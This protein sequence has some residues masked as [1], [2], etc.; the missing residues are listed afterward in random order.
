MAEYPKLSWDWGT[1]YDL[2]ISLEVLHHPSEFGVRGSWASSVR[3]RLRAPERDV[4]EQSLYLIHLP[5]HWV[6]A[7]PDPKDAS[8]V[9][10]SLG[11]IPAAERLSH[12]IFHDDDCTIENL[13][14][15]VAARRDWTDEDLRAFQDAVLRED[16]K[17]PSSLEELAKTLDGWANAEEFGE[18]YLEALQTYQEVFFSEEE[19]RIKPALEKALAKA[20]ALAEELELPDLLEELSQG[21]RFTE[22]PNLVEL[23]LAPSYWV[24]PLMYFG[25]VSHDRGV[26][27]FGA[28]PANESLVPGE[29]V[30]D[31][32][33]R[34]LKA[35]SDPTRLKILHYLS[36]EALS[37]VELS[38]RLR[39][40]PP[41]V[42]HHLQALRLAGLVKVNLGS[43]YGKEKKTFETRTETVKATY[44]ALETYISQGMTE[45]LLDDE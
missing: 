38:R 20:Q 27:M 42:T 44:A 15:D 18:R 19:K 34:V 11:Q 40:R 32:L 6:H 35:V 4:L 16:E 17:K 29:T 33:L 12:L 25:K 5:L 37:P 8:A 3:K 41:T 22:I 30:P 45:D 7:L 21:L 43:G 13:L 9:L 39:L 2:F 10:Y 23:S 31:A 1:A 28:R 26:W 24:T 14:K 36:Q